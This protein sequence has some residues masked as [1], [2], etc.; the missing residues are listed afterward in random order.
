[1]GSFPEGKEY[2]RCRHC[3]TQVDISYVDT[4]STRQEQLKNMT[5][6]CQYQCPAC[7]NLSYS[8]V[9]LYDNNEQTVRLA[10]AIMQAVRKFIKQCKEKGR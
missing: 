8:F 9:F 6:I 3:D 2:V 10:N 7:A 1:M 4:G 5:D